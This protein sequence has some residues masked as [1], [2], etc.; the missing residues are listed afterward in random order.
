MSTLPPTPLKLWLACAAVA[1]LAACGDDLTDD[2]PAT[3]A[4]TDNADASFDATATDADVP[5]DVAADVVADAAPKPCSADKVASCDDGLAC[6]TDSCVLGTCEWV[7]KP[8]FAFINGTCHTSGAKDPDNT[9]A[10][11]VPDIDPYHWTPL[12]DGSP[13]DD[14]S[15]CT[16]SDV[17][18]AHQ[19]LGEP[20]TCDDGLPCTADACLPETGC[21][22]VALPGQPTCDDEDACSQGDHCIAGDCIGQPVTCDDANPCTND[23]CN[24]GQGCVV[25]AST[26]ECSDGNACTTG[27][28][29]AKGACVAGEPTSCDD[30]NTCSIDVCEPLLGCYHLATQ[31]PCCVGQVSICDDGDSC[32]S[33]LCDP[34]SG[35]CNYSFNTAVCSDGNACTQGDTCAEGACKGKAAS[36]SDANPCTTD[37]CDPSKGCVHSAVAGGPCDDGS[38]CT[39]DDACVAGVCKGKGQCSC[40]PSFSKEATKLWSVLIGNGGKPGEGLDLDNNTATCAPA[41]NCSGGIDNALGALAGVANPQLDTAVAAGSLMLVLEYKDFKQGPIQVAL[42][43]AEL[44]PDNAS[45]DHQKQT[46]AY[47]V[48]SSLLDPVT[49][50]PVVSLPGNLAGNALKAGGPGTNFPF[51]LPIQGGVNLDITIYGARLQGTVTLTGGKVAAVDAIL[52]GAVPKQDLLTAIDAL[53]E[54][55]LPLPKDSLKGLLDLLVVN[56]VDSNGDGTKD[57]ASIALKLKGIPAVLAGTKP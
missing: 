37:A 54:E 49:C 27:D 21:G 41:N 32:T 5:Q 16:I 7:L 12:V 46:C 26:V 9:C 35:G 25:T 51:S 30:G 22:Y 19:C 36:C 15:A 40:T 31:N 55:G 52:A 47:L 20:V 2:T 38:P 56:D 24:P 33:D 48:S 28:V 4:P 50:A 23:T 17:C 45:C 53:P 3:D 39:Q 1:V 57:A 10:V 14:G 44:S 34:A 8:G 13:C 29:C 11:A 42:Y 6:T 18:K 43:Q